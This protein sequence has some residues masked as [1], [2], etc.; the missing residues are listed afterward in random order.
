[1]LNLKKVQYH[2]Y[3]YIHFI[4]GKI[5]TGMLLEDLISFSAGLP[6][7]SSRSSSADSDVS[8]AGFASPDVNARKALLASLRASAMK[9][10][11]I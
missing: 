10:M 2:N 3:F 4:M 11:I 8:G 5:L 9:A 7:I 1:M 6:S